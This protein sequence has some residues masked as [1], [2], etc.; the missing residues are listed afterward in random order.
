MAPL[1]ASANDPANW[2]QWPFREGLPVPQSRNKE[3]ATLLLP[4]LSTRSKSAG[5]RWRHVCILSFS[6]EG[7]TR[8]EQFTALKGV[9]FVWQMCYLQ[10]NFQ[11]VSS[12]HSGDFRDLQ[13]YFRK[14]TCIKYRLAVTEIQRTVRHS[15][16]SMRLVISEDVPASSRKCLNNHF[17]F[18]VMNAPT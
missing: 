6:K 2:I 15:P 12:L 16:A 4:E 1:R 13:M 10:R 3:G 9:L 17:N 18:Q 14:S 8:L 5:R 11:F 7:S